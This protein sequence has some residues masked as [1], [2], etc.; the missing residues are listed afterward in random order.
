MLSLLKIK[1]LALVDELEWQLG[2]GL[3]GV[4]GETGAL[5]EVRNFSK[6]AFILEEIYRGSITLRPSAIRK[7]VVS[8]CGSKAFSDRLSQYYESVFEAGK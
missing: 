7:H 4:T 6:I 1:N 8:L 3:V 2:S 5:A